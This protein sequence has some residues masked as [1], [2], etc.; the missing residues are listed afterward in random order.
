MRKVRRSHTKSRKGCLQCKNGHVKVSRKLFIS[1]DENGVY[2][3]IEVFVGRWG[4]AHVSGPR[5]VPERLR[6]PFDISLVQW[7]HV[8]DCEN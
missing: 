6:L 8:G 2:T 4:W 3:S 5:S 7:N 1:K